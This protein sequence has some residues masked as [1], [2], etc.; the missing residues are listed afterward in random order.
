MAILR[1]VDLCKKFTLLLLQLIW[2]SLKET[3]S[4]EAF[5][6]ASNIILHYVIHLHVNECSI[7]QKNQKEKRILFSTLLMRLKTAAVSTV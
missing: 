7:S 1:D 6:L 5:N 2:F 4:I 3:V